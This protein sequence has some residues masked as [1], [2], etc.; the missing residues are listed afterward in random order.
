MTI[1]GLWRYGDWRRMA[2][3]CTA[4]VS[5]T[6]VQLITSR[7]VGHIT[8]NAAMYADIQADWWRVQADSNKGWKYSSHSQSKTGLPNDVISRR[9][10]NCP[11]AF[12]FEASLMYRTVTGM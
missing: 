6:N 8:D 12:Q 9:G 10:L 1:A 2:T 7:F 3:G 11:S 4:L 5:P